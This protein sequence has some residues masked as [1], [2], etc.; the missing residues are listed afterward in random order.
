MTEITPF[1]PILP[2]SQANS[3]EAED[4]CRPRFSIR[5]GPNL[6]SKRIAGTDSLTLA[7]ICAKSKFLCSMEVVPDGGR[8]VGCWDRIEVHAAEGPQRVDRAVSSPL[9]IISLGDVGGDDG[10]TV[11]SRLATACR[12]C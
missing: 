11:L 10:V 6:G 8:L 1:L 9:S 3:L 5:S 7:R 12:R 2:L 4:R